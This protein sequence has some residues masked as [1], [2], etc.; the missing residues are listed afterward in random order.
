V[1]RDRAVSDPSATVKLLKWGQSKAVGV[2]IRRGALPSVLTQRL[3][4]HTRPIGN[5]DFAALILTSALGP[6]AGAAS[7]GVAREAHR[8]EVEADRADVRRSRTCD[9]QP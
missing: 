6:R 9:T 5:D 2:D 8:S 7:G 4:S 3:R 1:G